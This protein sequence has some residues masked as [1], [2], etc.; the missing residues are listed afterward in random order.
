MALSCLI[1]M[2]M[3]LKIIFYIYYKQLSPTEVETCKLGLVL[4][5][6]FFIFEYIVSDSSVLFCLF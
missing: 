1:W 5:T 2:I 4:F 3:S 6:S